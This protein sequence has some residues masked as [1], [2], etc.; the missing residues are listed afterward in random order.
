MSPVAASTTTGAT[1]PSPHASEPRSPGRRL[2]LVRIGWGIAALI[3]IGTFAA[4]LPGHYADLQRLCTGPIC[5]YGQL[6]PSAAH[7]FALLGIALDSYAV[8]R[9]GLTLLVALTWFVIAAMLAW[10]K[11][12]DWLALLVALWF[13]IVGT[14]TITGAFGLGSTVQAHEL[15]AHAVN[16]GAESGAILVLFALFPT[17]R[18]APRA[19]FWLLIVIGFFVAGLSAPGDSPLTL[20]LRL[21]VL[22]GVMVAQIYHLWRFTGRE[23][24]RQCHGTT[25]GLTVVIGVAMGFLVIAYIGRSLT[26]LAYLL[27][28][29][30]LVG[31][32]AMQLSRY[33]QVADPLGR[34]QTKWIAFGI[35]VFVTL[36]AV[37]QVPVL[38]LPSLGTSSAFYQTI[39]T[40]V[41]IVA[42]L[43]VP[44]TT[45]IAILRYRLWD[46][47]GLI[48][49]T[50][51]YGSLTGLLGAL[52]A[53]L[54]VGLE[55]LA[56]LMNKQAAQP[57][58]LVV[59][60]L[61]IA[62]LV[63]PLRNRLQHVIDRRFYRRKYDAE[64]TLAA[65]SA[66]LQ[67]EV[68]LE[69]VRG[70]LLGVIEETMQPTQVNLWLR[71]PMEHPVD[72]SY[73]W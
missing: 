25:L 67:N 5:A 73:H 46:I 17:R 37:L 38:F 10:R 45:T 58:V 4:R 35:A 27:Y 19:A 61:A 71:Q 30:V 13:I 2:V 36:G 28:I 3:G 16:L 21:G 66:A 12:N 57:L 14:A 34:Q 54:L 70:Q 48:N 41:L 31:A 33:W 63:Q 23:Q 7:A 65:F 64:K 68:D 50:L 40:L 44:V 52:Y 32:Y 9:S 18:F 42:S 43:V 60:T 26:T 62:A 20:S 47:D 55:S 49:Q 22:A 39:H 8:L 72:H 1:P 11:A 29:M 69:Q 51:V 56:G 15:Y 6:S 59:S 53:S 24:E